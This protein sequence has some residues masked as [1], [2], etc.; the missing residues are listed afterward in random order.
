[1]QILETK[2]E[3]LLVL[4]PKVFMDDRGWFM[5]SYNK[6]TLHRLGIDIEFVQDNHSFSKQKGVLRGLHFQNDPS[7]QIK[8][9][10]CTLGSILDV[11]V[12][13]RQGSPTYGQWFSIELTETNKKQLLIPS[14]FAHGF[15][16]LSDA[17]EI[18]YK[19]DHV[20]DKSC[21][22][23]IRFDDPEIG[24]QWPKMDYLVSEKDALAPL[25]KNSDANFVYHKPVK[26][27]D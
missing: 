10:R 15:L 12:D 19:V 26:H 4:E 25:L 17:A 7:A 18:Q 16:V 22:R 21:D 27:K 2:L 3:G 11:A 23:G 8:L 13:I 24:I 5:E 1:M 9:V 6:E 14:G 20:Y